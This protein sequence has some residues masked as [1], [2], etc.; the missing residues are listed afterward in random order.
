MGVRE[1]LGAGAVV[2]GVGA[3]LLPGGAVGAPLALE[4]DVVPVSHETKERQYPV[5]ASSGED[6]D[7]QT[8]RVIEGT[9]N[10][11]ENYLAATSNGRLLDLGGT[12]LRFTDDG[13]VSWRAVLPATPLIVAEGA[14]VGAPGGDVVAAT[15]SPY[16]GDRVVSFKYEASEDTWYSTEVP[17][18]TPFY[19][20]PWI[21]VV[22]GPVRGPTGEAPYLTA[23]K[24][25]SPSKGTWS[26]SF[27]GLNYTRPANPFVES[28]I[29]GVANGLP[30]LD[31][32]VDA[33]WVQPHT[34]GGITPLNGAGALASADVLEP[35]PR[36]LLDTELGWSCLESQGLPPAGRV[37]ADSEG[38]LH[39]VGASGDGVSY[40]LSTDGGSTWQSVQAPLPGA[41]EVED[42]DFKTNAD[43]ELTAVAVHAHDGADEAD[44]DFILRF[45]TQG[46]S[47]VLDRTLFVGDGDLNAGSGFGVDIRFDFA[48]MAILPDGRVAA[49]FIDAEHPTPSVAIE[50]P[51]A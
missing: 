51:S 26:Y 30:Q 45:T 40:A 43:L 9:G 17:L 21:A 38:R 10:C 1:L 12:L 35:C 25:G 42:W 4:A 16:S 14:V 28:T 8:W 49:S 37:L 20:R 6:L 31:P 19:D 2:L 47:P 46:G 44:Q 18:H 3:L 15:W 27:D 50:L 33:D 48:S 13:G 41:H 34:E 7:P 5:Q 32:H 39:V 24:G 22:P 23:L 11:C 29:G 36:R